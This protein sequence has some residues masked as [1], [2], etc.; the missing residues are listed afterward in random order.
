MVTKITSP[1][2]P[3]EVIDKINE[4]VDDKQDTLVSGTNIKTI[5]N[6]S[7]LGSGNITLPTVNDATLTITQ[8]GTTKGTFTANASSD[9]TIALDSGGGS[10]D[11]DNKSITTNASDQIQAVGV[12]NS[13]DSSTAVKTWTGTKAQYDAIVTKDANTLY[14]ITDDS[15]SGS[16]IYSKTEVDSLLDTKADVSLSNM[17]PTQTVKDT[18]VGWGMPDWSNA[19][20]I[21]Q[22]TMLS[23]YT[24]PSDGIVCGRYNPTNTNSYIKVNDV[25]VSG[26]DNEITPLFSLVNKNDVVTAG[27]M[28]STYW[29]I[30]FVP[31]KGVN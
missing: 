1:V 31:F 11:V 25:W 30:S 22:S 18:I 14:N 6:T 24:C 12:I 9:V 19:V 21:S 15:T 16:D 17:N 27:S 28:D 26:G 3:L 7:I 4:V 10:V 29:N 23:G 2:T 5:N 13:R 8:G 20:T